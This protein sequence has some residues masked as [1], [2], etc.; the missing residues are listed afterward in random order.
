M[1]SNSRTPSSENRNGGRRDITTAPK[2][3]VNNGYKAAARRIGCGRRL[4]AEVCARDQGELK[5]ASA[6]EIRAVGAHTALIG[7]TRIL[8]A[9]GCDFEAKNDEPQYGTE[10]EFIEWIHG[11]II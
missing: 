3:D 11:F 1:S 8:G 10:F 2:G 4:M 5:L 9:Q 6:G 7:E